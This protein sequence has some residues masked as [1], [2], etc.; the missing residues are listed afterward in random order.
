MQTASYTK[1]MPCCRA[2]PCPPVLQIVQAL[3]VSLTATA[4]EGKL[5]VGRAVGKT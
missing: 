5:K 4:K 2:T 3:L 1:I